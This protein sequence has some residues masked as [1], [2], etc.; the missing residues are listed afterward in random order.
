MEKTTNNN[1]AHSAVGEAYITHMGNR[2]ERETVEKEMVLAKISAF[3]QE[4]MLEPI[5]QTQRAVCENFKIISNN[6]NNPYE[7]ACE[8]FKNLI[9][10]LANIKLSDL[11][12]ESYKKS[13]RKVEKKHNKKQEKQFFDQIFK[14]FEGYS[15]FKNI[16]T[17]WCPANGKLLET[18][19]DLKNGIEIST[20]EKERLK[21]Y[22]ERSKEYLSEL[23]L[24]TNELIDHIFPEFLNNNEIRAEYSPENLRLILIKKLPANEEE[25]SFYYQSYAKLQLMNIY[26]EVKLNYD[27]PQALASTTHIKNELQSFAEHPKNNKFCEKISFVFHEGPTINIKNPETDK[28][29]NVQNGDMMYLPSEEMK[30]EYI[31]LIEKPPTFSEGIILKSDTDI[32][33]CPIFAIGTTKQLPSVVL[34]YI[35]KRYIQD[36]INNIHGITDL[37]RGTLYFPCTSK[38]EKL[39]TSEKTQAAVELFGIVE[40]LWGSNNIPDNYKNTYKESKNPFSTNEYHRIKTTLKLRCGF[41]EKDILKISGELKELIEQNPEIFDLFEQEIHLNE[42]NSFYKKNL[43]HYINMLKRRKEQ[44]REKRTPKNHEIS[45]IEKRMEAAIKI[46]DLFS[47]LIIMCKQ[48]DP[49][50]FF[51]KTEEKKI[52]F[53]ING[54]INEKTT[55]LKPMEIQIKQYNKQHETGDHDKYVGRK[56]KIIGRKLGIIQQKNKDKSTHRVVNLAEHL[57]GLLETYFNLHKICL[58]NKKNITDEHGNQILHLNSEET[59]YNKYS[60]ILE[61]IIEILSQQQNRD[62]LY[63]Q[64]LEY[65]DL[66]KNLRKFC[67]SLKPRETDEQLA[68]SKEIQEKTNEFRNSFMATLHNIK[69]ANLYS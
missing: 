64:I 17:I 28:I 8:Y 3:L 42:R 39:S 58:Y 46:K 60:V 50:P 52:K 19:D 43:N 67:K 41:N 63:E 18:M 26:N 69:L 47:Q 7:S 37:I 54:E 32:F 2:E 66:E 40:E 22:Q 27:Y 35:N 15:W 10:D 53:T 24:E 11:I 62:K 6:T 68:Y 36:E 34:K 14:H 5:R 31:S 48:I 30:N 44:E 61:N 12:S 23:S 13:K 29:Y 21:K 56:N 55:D 59:H 45:E 51:Q 38:F 33:E 65:P 57:D 49:I 16:D 25:I 1:I 20:E 9:E 4:L